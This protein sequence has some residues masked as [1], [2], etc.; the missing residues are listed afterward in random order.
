LAELLKQS[1][2]S[3]AELD[4][5]TLLERS[6][7]LLPEDKVIFSALSMVSRYRELSDTAPP[8]RTHY[9]PSK[10]DTNLIRE[11]TEAAF[12][13]AM[14]ANTA[15]NYASSLRKLVAA[16]RPLSIAK[17]SHKALLGYA[18]ALFPNDKSLIYALNR[19]NDYRRIAGRDNSPS[20]VDDSRQ[21]AAGRRFARPAFRT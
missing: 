19:L 14:D 21:P 6:K 18:D 17:L 16:L 15:G 4:D 9:R 13:R 8:L 20:Y 2:Y 5:D 11:A 3:I 10:E 7:T 12:G 1:G